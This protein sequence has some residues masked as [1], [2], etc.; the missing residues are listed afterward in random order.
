MLQILDRACEGE[1][2]HTNASWIPEL[3]F[4]TGT[5]ISLGLIG[6]LLNLV[7]LARPTLWS[8]TYTYFG[9]LSSANLGVLLCSI[10]SS[11]RLR[12]YPFMELMSANIF[13][14]A[15][16]LIMLCM[17]VERY[18]MICWP[19]TCKN[20]HSSRYAVVLTAVCYV[21]AGAISYPVAIAACRWKYFSAF[22]RIQPTIILTSLNIQIVM[23]FQ[24]VSDK[25]K[26]FRA[27]SDKFRTRQT[28]PVTGS[29]T[30]QDSLRKSSYY[31]QRRLVILLILLLVLYSVTIFPSSVAVLMNDETALMRAVVYCL[32]LANFSLTFYLYLLWSKEIRRE[33]GKLCCRHPNNNILTE[34][35]ALYME[36][37][38]K[39]RATSLQHSK[40]LRS[41]SSTSSKEE[42][43]VQ[44]G[45][46]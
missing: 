40:T 25:K 17:T 3:P 2:W 18:L 39:N 19:N 1:F 41:V 15:S 27:A 33:L 36:D 45:C 43:D 9:S 37:S 29:E 16:V 8:A 28:S 42:E 46:Q 7:V 6:N 31:E 20:I 35:D 13:E 38:A 21:L 32:E 4:A 5:I 23:R 14:A 34:E 12:G 30:H 24:K 11:L 26:R 10:P 22:A 44:Q